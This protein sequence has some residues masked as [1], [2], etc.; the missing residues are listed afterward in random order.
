MALIPGLTT[1]AFY[2]TMHR[3]AAAA[4]EALGVDLVF[5]G[6]TAFNPVQQVPVLDAVVARHPDLILI[7]PTDKTQFVEPL[8][9]AFNAGLNATS[10]SGT[11]NSASKSSANGQG[12]IDRSEKLQTSVAAVVTEVLPDGNLVVS[13]SQE[14]RVNFELRQLSVAG[15]IRPH[16]ISKDNTIPYEKIAEARISYGGRGRLSEVQQPGW[17]QQLYDNF[18]PF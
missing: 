12:T 14:V 4:A 3:G 2:I 6:S 8:R 11:F 5:Q 17:G 10:I 1:D 18:K 13:G 7:A 16:D 9:N 15:I